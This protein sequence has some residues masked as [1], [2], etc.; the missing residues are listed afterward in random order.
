MA[1]LITPDTLILASDITEQIYKPGSTSE[2]IFMSLLAVTS[3]VAVAAILFKFL[4]LTKTRIIP[5]SLAKDVDAFEQRVT[6]GKAA[7]IITEFQ[8]GN[9]VLARL[10]AVA[11][12]QRGKPQTEIAEVVRSMARTELV[13]LH[14]GMAAI[15]V[16]ISVAPLLG[17]LGTASGL[18]QVFNGLQEDGDWIEI[19]AGIGQAL[20]TTI[21]GMA[22]S[23]PAIIAQGY[24]QRKI[25]KH[26]AR[27]EVLLTK[28]A[29][30]CEHRPDLGL[31]DSEEV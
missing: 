29:Y 14:S 3:L 16:V 15:E 31:N 27:L 5:G 23:V 2:A 21:F 20:K 12:S 26:A 25:D 11:V 4:T 10:G 24:F 7:P 9:S 6:D 22:I 19:A 1:S 18:D 30:V 17:L 13:G 28:V 8:N